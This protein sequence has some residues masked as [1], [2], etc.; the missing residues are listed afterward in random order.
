MLL[1]PQ[2]NRREKRWKKEK[3][4]GGGEVEEKERE[5]FIFSLSLFFALNEDSTIPE[6]LLSLNLTR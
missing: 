2:K 5:S 4:E 1:M 6:L 3:K